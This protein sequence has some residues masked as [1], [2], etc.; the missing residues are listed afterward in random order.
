MAKILVAE[1]EPAVREF[2]SRAL[3]HEGHEVRGV[4]DGLQALAVLDEEE[5]DLLLTDIVMPGMDGIALALKVSSDKP[6]LPIL[7]MS[8]YAAERQRAHNLEMIIH[9]IIAKPFT[10]NEIVNAVNGL[11]KKD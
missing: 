5:F 10:L 1:D 7:M 6:D 3:T 2:V 11:L 8:G 9:K 4:E